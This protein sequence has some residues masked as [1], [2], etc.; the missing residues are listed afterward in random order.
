MEKETH[1]YQHYIPECY[2]KNFTEN[3]KSF[4]V[5][6]K[7]NHGKIYTKSISDVAGKKRFY[8]IEDKFLIKDFKSKNKYL[9]KEVF[10][11]GFEPFL[12]N[13]LLKIITSVKNWNKIDFENAVLTEMERDYFAELIGLQ[14][15]R[16]PNF[17][18]K[19]WNLHKDLYPK[20]LEIIKSFLPKTDKNIEVLNLGFDENYSSALHSHFILDNKWR[21]FIQEQL[22]NKIW[23]FYYS[24]ENVITSDNPILLKP[25]IPNKKPFYEG[26][27]MKGVEIIFPISKNIILTI[28]DENHFSKKKDLNNSIQMLDSKSLR[29]YN[30]YQYCFANFEIYSSSND[31]SVI[32]NFIKLNNNNDY[33]TTKSKIQVY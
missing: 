25:H 21:Y 31:I 3:G 17:I 6:R 10:A 5:Y 19:Y 4:F 16:H 11:S 14:Y 33:N 9:E 26:F 1:I 28:W 27:G 8:D 22:I 29:E 12:N 18:E 7:N 24:E 23:I 30:I 20:R 2:L 32:Q 13:I 15:I